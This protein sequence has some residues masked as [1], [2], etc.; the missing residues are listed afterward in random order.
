[1][2]NTAPATARKSTWWTALLVASLMANLLFAG[3]VI[4]NRYWARQASERMAGVTMVQVV[5]RGFFTQLPRER[6]REL[7]RDVREEMGNLRQHR[8]GT[9]PE[10][11][12]LADIL[13]QESFSAD[14][15]STAIDTFSTGPDSLAVRGSKVLK[16]LIGKLTPE[17]RK[18]LAAA[19]RTRA[20][21]EKNRKW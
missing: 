12:K 4:G 16:D 14:N 8:S 17:E 1:M 19:M 15:A 21:R 20:E 18:Q 13:E 9:S 2:S 11:L 10:I 5:P 6:R 7:L 3:W